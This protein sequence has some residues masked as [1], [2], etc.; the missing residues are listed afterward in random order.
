MLRQQNLNRCG[1]KATTGEE[2]RGWLTPWKLFRSRLSPLIVRQAL[3]MSSRSGSC[4]WSSSQDSF[5]FSRELWILSRVFLMRRAVSLAEG[6]W[7]QHSLISLTSAERVWEKQMTVRRSSSWRHVW[8]WD[9]HSP[10]QRTSGWEWTASAA[11]HTPPSSCP[12][13]SG[14]SSPG[15][16]TEACTPPR[17]LSHQR[18][19][20]SVTSGLPNPRLISDSHHCCRCVWLSPTAPSRRPRCPLSCRRRSS[21]SGCSRPEPRVPCSAWCPLLGCCP[22]PAGCQPASVSQPGLQAVTHTVTAGES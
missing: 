15:R 6:F 17:Y 3:S 7:Y 16:R 9:G 11:P 18:T 22:H 12:Q 10:D 14:H 1:W 5:P 4:L 13:S 20:I 8:V 21:P 2:G 19:D